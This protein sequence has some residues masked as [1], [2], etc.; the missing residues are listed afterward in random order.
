MAGFFN[1]VTS[2]FL[3]NDIPEF[4]KEL[5]TLGVKS[6]IE[7]LKNSH[8][9]GYNQESVI[10]NASEDMEEYEFLNL[11]NTAS[12]KYL[13]FFDSDYKERRPQYRSIAKEAEI[14][15]ILTKISNE[16]IVYDDDNFF[17]NVSDIKLDLKNKKVIQKDLERNFKSI[18][19][20]YGFNDNTTGWWLFMKF[21]IDGFICFE[22]IYSEKN[23]TIIGFKEL[24]PTTLKL[25]ITPEGD[26]VWVQFEGDAVKQR[27][28]YDSQLV[29]ISYASS[30]IESRIAYIENLIKPFNLLEMMEQT[31]S[32]WAVS[33]ATM[34]LKFVIPVGGKSKNVAKQTLRKLMNRY[35]EEIS[36][37]NTSGQYKVNG[38]A[39]IPGVKQIWM[40]EKDGESPTIENFGGDGPPM[41]D[42]DILT[43]FRKKLQIASKI[44]ASR[45]DPQGND[46]FANSDANQITQEEIEFNRFI[47]QLRS[48]FKEILIKPLYLQMVLDHPKLKE[49]KQ[50]KNAVGITFS[51]YNLFEKFKEYEVENKKIQQ[52]QNWMGITDPMGNPFCSMTFLVKKYEL[53]TEEELRENDKQKKKD[54]EKA[55]ENGEQ[56]NFG[57]FGGG[58]GQPQPGQEGQSQDDSGMQ[59]QIDNLDLAAPNNQPNEQD[60]EKDDFKV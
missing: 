22:I 27:I 35:N 5:G 25:S 7:I 43:Y 45:F 41:N 56:Q 21:L 19:N 24:D 60:E 31:R 3:Q 58:F 30:L 44:P 17:A 9:I 15:N 11:I 14:H 39:Y 59:S 34:R 46:I 12:N 23:E 32:T 28:L 48:I 33:N 1:S 37:D 36:F 26:Q 2:S 51:Q 10:Q 29:Y 53:L 4:L 38:K 13:P 57:G 20:L 6:K 54:A 49:D 47:I 50:F 52:I 8:S 55:K 42:T 16:A 18:Y 40:P